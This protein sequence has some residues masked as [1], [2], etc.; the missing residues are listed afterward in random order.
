MMRSTRFPISS[1]P[2]TPTSPSISGRSVKSE[3]FWRSAKQP[4]MTTPRIFP[5][6]LS[7]SIWSIASNDSFLAFSINPQVLITTK[8]DSS[9]FW[10]NW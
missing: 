1:R 5:E 3:S 6:R 2:K 7:S 10:T 9:G 8:S 4:V